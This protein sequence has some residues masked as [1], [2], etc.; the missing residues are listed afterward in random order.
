MRNL[1]WSDAYGQ[2]KSMTA[3]TKICYVCHKHAV[4]QTV[5]YEKQ[6][7]KLW[8]NQW[9]QASYSKQ[10]FIYCKIRKNCKTHV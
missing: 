1:S 5:F 2:R 6:Y 4:G 9:K 8:Q 7:R 3:M 10:E